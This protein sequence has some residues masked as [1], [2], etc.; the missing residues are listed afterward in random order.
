MVKAP[1]IKMQL[2]LFEGLLFKESILLGQIS[3]SEAITKILNFLT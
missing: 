1:D 3:G 2:Y